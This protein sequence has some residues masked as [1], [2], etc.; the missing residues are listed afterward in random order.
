MFEEL[1]LALGKHQ[2]PPD[3]DQVSGI[4]PNQVRALI[5]IAEA[6]QEVWDSVPGTYDA[7]DP[8]VQRHAAALNALGAALKLP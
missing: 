1:K 8:A 5:A 7:N 2:G 4:T 3:Y 6:A